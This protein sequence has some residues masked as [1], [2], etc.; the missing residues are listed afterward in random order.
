MV[1]LWFQNFLPVTQKFQLFTWSQD[2]WKI[3]MT[4]VMD[5]GLLYLYIS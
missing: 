5:G 3:N 1:K 4:E 2:I